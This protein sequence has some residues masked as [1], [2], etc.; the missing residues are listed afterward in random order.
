MAAIG[1]RTD[2]SEA[3]S[4]GLAR[5]LN[6]STNQYARHKQ[7]FELGANTQRTRHMLH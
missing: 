3:G 5:L 6:G 2:V 4:L 1:G 7:D